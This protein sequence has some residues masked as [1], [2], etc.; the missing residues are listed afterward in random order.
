MKRASRR[1]LQT[2]VYRKPEGEP[3]A[4]QEIAIVRLC[5]ESYD[6]YQNSRRFDETESETEPDAEDNN[7]PDD[8]T[9]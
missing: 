3:D 2:T 5:D 4:Q 1:T 8:D 7:V 9:G 6:E